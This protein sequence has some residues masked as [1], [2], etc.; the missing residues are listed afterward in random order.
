MPEMVQSNQRFFT[1]AAA[2]ASHAYGLSRFRFRVGDLVERAM[3]RADVLLTKDTIIHIPNAAIQSFLRR[4]VYATG[5]R[6]RDLSIPAPLQLLTSRV[7][8]AA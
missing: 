2:N 5:D 8:C 7:R 4:S 6:T 1:T 3:P